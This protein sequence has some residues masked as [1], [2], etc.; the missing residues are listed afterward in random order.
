[1]ILIAFFAQFLGVSIYGINQLVMK[2]VEFN[3][4]NPQNCPNLSANVC[5]II[6]ISESCLSVLELILSTIG[7]S[8]QILMYSIVTFR[9]IVRYIRNRILLNIHISSSSS[10]LQHLI[11]ENNIAYRMKQED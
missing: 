2:L 5:E 8:I 10:P 6:F 11:E 3:P 4:V 1:M 7:T 9:R